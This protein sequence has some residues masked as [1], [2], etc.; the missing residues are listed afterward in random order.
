[1]ESITRT[2]LLKLCVFASILLVGFIVLTQ[3]DEGT[4]VPEA[5][6]E[7]DV[8]AFFQVDA[9]HEL[10]TVRYFNL[11]D[12]EKSGDS[13]LIKSPEGKTLL[14]D[15]GNVNM[16]DQLNELLDRLGVESLDY[17]VATHP[18]HDH[19]GGFFSLIS[20][21]GID[22]FYMPEIPVV[23]KVNQAFHQ[24]LAKRQ[25]HVDYLKKGDTFK[26]GSQVEIEV[27]NPGEILNKKKWSTKQINQ[28]AL[29][30]KVTYQNNTFLLAS[31]IYKPTE[32]KLIEEYGI[33]LQADVLHIPHH[34]HRTSSSKDFIEMANPKYAIIS[35]N[36][37]NWKKVYKRLVGQG[38]DVYVTEK[39]GHIYIRSDGSSVEVSPDGN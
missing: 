8:G 3:G 9:D 37:S 12:K 31:D 26:L 24:L 19:I 36:T 32:A 4:I 33:K 5:S 10:L 7:D 23:S 28:L 6:A 2:H 16:G 22:H 1:M 30:L 20:S 11:K 15:S 27:L 21:R 39:D 25:I 17:A 29:V 13:I 18:H 38:I 34:G 14:I 35:S